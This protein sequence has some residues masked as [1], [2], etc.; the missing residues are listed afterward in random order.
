MTE[1]WKMLFPPYEEAAR[2]AAEA[3]AQGWYGAYIAENQ[4]LVPDPYVCLAMAATGTERLRL[5]TGVTNPFTRHPAVTTERDRVD[6]PALRRPAMLGIGRG[7]SALAYLGRRPVST[8]TL[9]TYLEQ[10]VGFLSGDEVVVDGFSCRNHWIPGSGLPRRA[11]RRRGFGAAHDRR[12]RLGS[13]TESRSRSARTRSGSNA[14]LRGRGRHATRRGSSPR[15]SSS[16]R[17]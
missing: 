4:Q 10:V 8:A 12:S 14:A 6:Q 11:G 9:E 5:A 15:A 2:A 13:P 17:T 1:F 16:G 3:E 7:D